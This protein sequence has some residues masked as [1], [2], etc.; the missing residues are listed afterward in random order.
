M[1]D[2]RIRAIKQ[3][4]LSNGLGNKVSVLSYSAK[5]ASCYYGPFRDAAQSKPAFGDR[6]CYQLPAG[7]RGLALRA[8]ERDVREGADMLMVKPGLPYLDIM[9]DVKDKVS[10]WSFFKQRELRVLHSLGGWSF[11]HLDDFH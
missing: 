9:R 5:F 10:S 3:A 1:M 2:G 7:A 4:L 11:P 8:V 6:R